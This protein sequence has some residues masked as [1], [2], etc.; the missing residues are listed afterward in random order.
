MPGCRVDGAF[1]SAGITPP[2]N[3]CGQCRPEISTT[4]LAPVNEGMSC[5]SGDPNTGVTTCQ[6]GACRGNDP[7]R[8][9][10]PTPCYLEGETDP[11]TGLCVNP[12]APA[13]TPCG[14]DAICAGGFFQPADACDGNGFCIGG[15]SQVI[16]CAPY[17]CAGNACADTCASDAECL[18]GTVCCAGR[19]VSLGTVDHCGACGDLCETADACTPASCIDGVCNS[20]SICTPVDACTPARCV[21]GV[22]N[23]TTAC[24]RV[25][26]C[27]PA[28]CING[29]CRST[30]ACQPVDACTPARC[31]SDGTCNQIS[32]CTGIT[33]CGGGGVSGQCG[34]TCGSGTTRCGNGCVA[35]A[36]IPSTPI[37]NQIAWLIAQ[38]NGGVD[39]LTLTEFN[40]HFTPGFDFSTV[41]AFLQ[42][43]AGF[44]PIVF[45]GFTGTPTGT[46]ASFLLVEGGAFQ[47][48]V[49]I[50][51]DPSTLLFTF[52]SFNIA[53]VCP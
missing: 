17:Q 5:W 53:A 31:L 33:T 18:G 7:Q 1:L 2:E 6:N 39:T 41:R 3:S 32:A 4:S 14:M 30:S 36:P 24:Q 50:T 46:S 20:A 43:F 28:E 16:N 52:L 11:V 21:N 26:A 22:C 10:P 38:L 44:R 8:C 45:G 48:P 15:G 37:G 23:A 12:P 35:T 19:C 40:Q 51:I 34:F 9:P 47:Q 29:V 13:G 25:D 49:D 42:G 27:T